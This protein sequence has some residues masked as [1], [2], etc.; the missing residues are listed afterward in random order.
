MD[1]DVSMRS[2]S[3][4]F[5]VKFFGAMVEEVR[6]YSSDTVRACCNCSHIETDC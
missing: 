3:C 1:L 6:V 5:A 2:G 4:P